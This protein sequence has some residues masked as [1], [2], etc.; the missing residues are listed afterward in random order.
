MTAAS[1]WGI[2]ERFVHGKRFRDRV[3]TQDV[4]QLDGLG[5]RRNRLG[6]E[7]RE[8]G[9]LVQDVVELPLQARQLLLGQPEAGEEGDVLHIGTGQVSH[10]RMIPD[11]AGSKPPAEEPGATMGRAAAHPFTARTGSSYVSDLQIRPMTLAD[12]HAA[13]DMMASGGWTERRGF[14]EWNLSNPAVELVVGTVDGRLAATGL[15][16]VNPSDAGPIGWVGSIFVDPEMRRHGYGQAIT[17]AVC[18]RL[19]AKGCQTLALIASDLG[20]PIYEKMGFRVDVWWEIWEAAPTTTPAE[21]APGTRLRRAGPDDL[22]AILALDR[23]ATAEDRRSLLAPFVSTG[24]LLE[25]EDGQ[26][27]LG[28]LVGME[29]RNA[30]VIAPDPLDAAC[31]LTILRNQAVDRTESVW[32]GAVQGNK[33]GQWLLA[34]SG[35]KKS[36]ET[37]RMLRGPGIGWDPTLIWSHL[38]FAYG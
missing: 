18:E 31:L 29:A 15:A 30:A 28:F 2:G 14:L 37:A 24:W 6:V 9:V 4:G 25:T 8:D 33:R 22:D 35:W 12:V 13:A 26:E 27:C 10:W 5:R 1:F 7:S 3:F 38:G 32:A 17:E 36:F 23:R 34:N 21:A 20:Q 11:R 19:E 16:T